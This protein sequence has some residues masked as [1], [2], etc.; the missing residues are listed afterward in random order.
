[1]FARSTRRHACLA[2]RP[3]STIEHLQA[4]AR[5]AHAEGIEACWL[6]LGHEPGIT[7][8]VASYDG[9]GAQ[10]VKVDTPGRLK[11]HLAKHRPI[12]VWIQTPY[13]EHYPDWFWTT[14]EGHPLCFA[15]YSIQMMTWEFGLYQLP[16][17]RQCRWILVES[18]NLRNGFV[19]NGVEADRVIVADNPILYELRHRQ[20]DRRIDDAVDLM[21][22]PHW[23]QDWFGQRGFSRWREVAPVLLEYARSHPDVRILVRPHPLLQRAVDATVDEEASAYR[24]LLRLPNVDLSRRSMADDVDRSRA[25]LSDGLSILAYFASTGKPLGIV[26]D[27]ESP[28]FNDLGYAILATSDQLSDPAAVAAWLERLPELTPDDRRRT[29]MTRLLPAFVDSPVAI[30]NRKRAEA[31]GG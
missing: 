6:D 24:D 18:N 31:V 15:Q 28:E 12:G 20:A 13:P 21:W 17:Y 7:D 14:V 30:W 8:L 29:M 1:M 23:S 16:T 5:Q 22:A 2:A 11:R 25:L 10:A 4:I 9:F 27:D 3:N 19:A 26:Y